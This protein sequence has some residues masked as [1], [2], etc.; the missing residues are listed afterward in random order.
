MWPAFSQPEVIINL[1]LS[2]ILMKMKAERKEL[3]EIMCREIE[4]RLFGALFFLLFLFLFSFLFLQKEKN[5]MQNVHV[6]FS[7]RLC[8]C[9]V[10]CFH[11]SNNR[12][13]KMTRDWTSWFVLL[14]AAM[15]KDGLFLIFFRTTTFKNQYCA[16]AIL[17]HQYSRLS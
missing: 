8:N 15:I 12:R 4:F 7:P 16:A 3:R 13:L 1:W 10:K 5:L 11:C 2:V 9:I 17:C 6:K 14:L